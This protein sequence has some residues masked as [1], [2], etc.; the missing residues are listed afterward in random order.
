M[1]RSRDL[2]SLFGLMEGFIEDSGE[3]ENKMVEE[4]L[5]PRREWR[6]PAFGVMVKRLDGSID[7]TWLFF[8]YQKPKGFIVDLKF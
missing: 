4:F 6:G 8:I 5:S 2:D 1:E 3:V 7:I